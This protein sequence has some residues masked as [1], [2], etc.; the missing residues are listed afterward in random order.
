MRRRG[1]Q[2]ADRLRA[3]PAAAFAALPDRERT[4]TVLFYGLDGETPRTHR[5]IAAR[6]RL[7]ASTVRD[8]VGRSVARLLAA[9]EDGLTSV[10]D[11]AG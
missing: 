7:S 9:A 6:L 5:E 11:R 8:A 1:R 2:D 4:I 3:L 10:A